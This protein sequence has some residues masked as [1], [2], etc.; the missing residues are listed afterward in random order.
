M[1]VY[2]LS[3]RIFFFKKNPLLEIY[4]VL[5]KFTL[6]EVTCCTKFSLLI[7]KKERKKKKQKGSFMI[8]FWVIKGDSN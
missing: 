2:Y 4:C 1:L 8:L 6:L 3:F 5:G 7:K